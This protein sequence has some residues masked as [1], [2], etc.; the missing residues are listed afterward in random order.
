[1]QSE[2]S[3]EPQ[4]AGALLQAW[5]QAYRQDFERDNGA[6]FTPLLQRFGLDVD[7]PAMLEGTIEFVEAMAAFRMLDNLDLVAFLAEQ[8]YDPKCTA[9]TYS[10]VFNVCGQGAARLLATP[11]LKSIDLAD[12]YGWPWHRLE[13]VGYYGFWV[14]RID[15]QALD[16]TEIEALDQQVSYD[17]AFDYGED[18][19]SVGFDP[20]SFEGALAVT[21]CDAPDE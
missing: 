12:L 4:P 16:A 21:I 1:M 14:H 20:D 10:L 11:D 8:R 13:V 6:M 9:A 18:E 15:G 2:T 19:V 3:T 5:A 17:I 7:A